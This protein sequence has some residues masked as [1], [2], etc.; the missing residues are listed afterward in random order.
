[1]Y[2]HAKQCCGETFA[3]FLENLPLPQIDASGIVQNTASLSALSL[4][5]KT[6]EL[7]DIKG[8]NKVEKSREIV[9]RATL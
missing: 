3:A 2:P 1:M 6:N 7:L 9:S 4:S 5:A 8:M